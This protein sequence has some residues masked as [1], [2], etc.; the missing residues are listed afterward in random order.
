MAKKPLLPSKALE[1]FDI[2]EIKQGK[3]FTE[4]RY[5]GKLGDRKWG[6]KGQL[7]AYKRTGRFSETKNLSKKNVD[8][9]Y[10]LIS[11][12]LKKHQ[13]AQS[14]IITRKDKI[15]INAEGLKLRRTAGSGFTKVDQKDL[16]KIVS[17]LQQQSQSAVFNDKKPGAEKLAKV[18][19]SRVMDRILEK[20]HEPNILESKDPVKPTIAIK[21]ALASPLPPTHSQAGQSSPVVMAPT[22]FAPGPNSGSQEAYQPPAPAAPL[23]G[24]TKPTFEP[25]DL[26]ID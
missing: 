1:N 19:Q 17:T 22:N 8:E 7:A 4:G 13:K 26:Q 16:K 24:E 14:A 5:G 6:L 18:R 21:P 25:R 20:E 11:E 12:R 9:I 10:R 23:T 15:K 2:S 3:Y